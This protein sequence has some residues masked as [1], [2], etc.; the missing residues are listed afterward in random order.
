MLTWFWKGSDHHNSSKNLLCL[1]IC[2][3]PAC[4]FAYL[5]CINDFILSQVEAEN[6]SPM[7]VPANICKRLFI[8][9]SA[10]SNS[11]NS[12]SYTGSLQKISRLLFF[13]EVE[14]SFLFVWLIGTTGHL[15]TDFMDCFL[16]PRNINRLF[17]DDNRLPIPCGRCHFFTLKFLRITSFMWD[18]HMPHIMPSIFKVV[19]IIVSAP[20]VISERFLFLHYVSNDA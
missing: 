3:T 4:A 15:I 5:F 14:Q 17:A 9:F 8:G 13:P 11:Y 1:F 18:S 20:F 7:S 16:C 6:Y 10:N 19:L 12:L 2:N